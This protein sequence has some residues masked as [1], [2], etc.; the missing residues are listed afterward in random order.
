MTLNPNIIEVGNEIRFE[1]VDYSILDKLAETIT[2][3]NYEW[4]TNINPPSPV[5]SVNK[6]NVFLDYLI[7]FIP[8]TKLNI[9]LATIGYDWELPYSAGITSVNSLTM[10]NAIKLA[11]NYGKIIQFD[12]VS[13]TPFFYYTTDNNVEHIVWFID[14]RSIKALLDLVTKYELLGTGIWNITVYNA[15]M[16]SIINALYEIEKIKL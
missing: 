13:Q 5:S 6:L 9:G 4:A 2:F 8:P 14:A 11:S 10:E 16:W 3:M 15:Q 1:Q 12:E 7:R